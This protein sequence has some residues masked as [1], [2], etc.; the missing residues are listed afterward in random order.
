MSFLTD[1]AD[2]AV[3]LPL[4]LAMAVL[5]TACG[6]GRGAMAWIACVGA[7]L[8]LTGFA[9]LLLA[10]CG[11]VQVGAGL[12]SPSGHTA[13]ATI[14]YGGLLCLGWRRAHPASAWLAV[15]AA[16][17]VSVAIGLTRVA[18]DAHTLP[19]VLAGGMVGGL[20]LAALLALA[21][22]PPQRLRPA[23]LA[24]V[25]VAVAILTHGL[26]VR[27]EPA[28]GEVARR[29]AALLPGCAAPVNQVRP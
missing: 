21:G 1:F 29:L 18:L 4:A 12:R 5:L 25:V 23:W 9:K 11:P 8:A 27:A 3:I 28:I 19:D 15:V 6:W 22:P 13:A 7:T 17:A 2:Q 24:I 20:G 26:H 14:V 10:A 16:L